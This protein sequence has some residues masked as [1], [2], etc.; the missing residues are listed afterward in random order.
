MLI[1]IHHHIH[2]TCIRSNYQIQLYRELPCYILFILCAFLDILFRGVWISG[3]F[4]AGYMP[5]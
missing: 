5:F 2:T 3:K 4:Q 1:D